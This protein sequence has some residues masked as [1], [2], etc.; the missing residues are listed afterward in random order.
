VITTFA[1]NTPVTT[2]V[3]EPTVAIA[4]LLLAHDPP[5][6][7]LLNVVVEPTQTEW[8][9]VFAE[10]TGITV[11]SVVAKHP[12]LSI[13][14]MF[15]VPAATPVTFPGLE[16]T[17]ATLVLLLLQVPPVGVLV[18]TVMVPIHAVL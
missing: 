3:P 6:V 7:E 15:E 18:S 14:V 2:P 5:D 10:G 9:P 4:V 13:Y 11:T 16:G 12:V 1:A 8:V 17:V